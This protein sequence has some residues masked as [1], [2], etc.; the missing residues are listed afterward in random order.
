MEVESRSVLDKISASGTKDHNQI[1][2]YIGQM[3]KNYEENAK[4]PQKYEILNDYMKVFTP[5]AYEGDPEKQ[6]RL[7]QELK[8]NQELQ[9]Q[10]AELTKRKSGGCC[11][12]CQIM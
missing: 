5:I 11:S 1:M 6:A 3:T 4:G 9:K 7:R 10:M 8:R 12:A 2:S